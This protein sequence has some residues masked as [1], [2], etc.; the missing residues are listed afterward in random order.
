MSPLTKS[1]SPDK[2]KAARR[3]SWIPLPEQTTRALPRSMTLG[4]LGSISQSPRDR[5]EERRPDESRRQGRFL[6][7]AIAGAERPSFRSRIPSAPKGILRSSYT[8]P[9][10]RSDTEP[11]LPPLGGATSG[12]TPGKDNVLP[13]SLTH[14]KLTI[15]RE[16]TNEKPL[17]PCPGRRSISTTRSPTDDKLRLKHAVI[18]ENKTHSDPPRARLIDIP[19][20]VLPRFNTQPN[21]A[22]NTPA[23]PLFR[24]KS[25]AVEIKHHAL[26][27]PKPPPSPVQ[28]TPLS[29]VTNVQRSASRLRLSRDKESPVTPIPRSTTPAEAPSPET[30]NPAAIINAQPIPYWVGRFLSQLD[31]WRTA[32]FN[33]RSTA[34]SCSLPN[35]TF[36]AGQEMEQREQ[37]RHIL[38]SLYADCESEDAKGSLQLF[39]SYLRALHVKTAVGE[40]VGVAEGV[41]WGEI[42]NEGELVRRRNQRGDNTPDSL[43]KMRRGTFMERLLGRRARM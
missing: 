35:S 7:D 34:S 40:E 5:K 8:R 4:N 1:T 39:Y 11:L 37:Y 13:R 28:R 43:G 6:P 26:L 12:P 23:T 38:C 30:F 20:R 42:C 22:V 3:G 15:F 18:K 19:R 32:D 9:L 31:R 2:T 24:A 10:P 21:L 29:S 41:S 16:R 33:R 25:R 36:G 27:S 14:S 17:P